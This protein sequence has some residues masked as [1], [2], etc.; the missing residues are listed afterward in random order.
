MHLVTG[1]A[2]AEHITATDQGAFNSAL[3]GTG[4]FVLDKG[5]V[6]EAQAISNNKVRVL[7]GELM[8]QGRFIRMNPDTHVDLTIE[9]GAQGLLRNDLIVARYTKDSITGLEGCDLVVIKGT[10]VASNPVDPAYTEADITNGGAVLNDF[11]LWRIPISGIN[12]GTPVSLFGDPFVDSMRTLP[13]IR[14]AVNQIHSEV[15]AQL[16]KQDKKMDQKI[17]SLEWMLP[18][19]IVTAMTGSVVTC[20]KDDIVL[21][22]EEVNGVWTFDVLG[23][24]E[25]VVEATNSASV[26]QSGT[27]TQIVT[28][29]NVKQYRVAASFSGKA[30]YTM[31]YDMGDEC[32]ALT[33][34]WVTT[35]ASVKNIS[36][37]L[38]KTTTGDGG[39]GTVAT[40][41]AVDFGENKGLFFF[42]SDLQFTNVRAALEIYAPTTVFSYRADVASSGVYSLSKPMTFDKPAS[43]GVV[44]IKVYNG[45]AYSNS[46]N[47]TTVYSVGMYGADDWGQLCNIA[48]VSAPST[49]AALLADASACKKILAS[50][51]AV[52]YMCLNCNGE[53]L[54]KA[55]ASS[56]FMAALAAS[57]FNSAVYANEHWA[58]FLALVA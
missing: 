58:K 35:G 36:N 39:E 38:A 13:E 1:Y 48:G 32:T 45:G 11:P 54:F 24:G 10:A 5:H 43:Y 20:T 33:D 23:Y 53:F 3:I 8:M 12:V 49:L 6:F 50:P 19:I 42:C 52:N 2:G 51:E 18:Q 27:F 46:V 30:N 21:T 34:G 7:D 17:D 57:E 22:A 9:S 15:D 41:R 31:L 37:M 40:L 16:A 29:D 14:N 25:W 28:V 4:Q 47:Q 56:T 44:K 26:G 55:M